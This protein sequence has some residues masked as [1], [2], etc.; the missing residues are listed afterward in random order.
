MGNSKY[1]P[2]NSGS[3]GSNYTLEIISI[4]NQIDPRTPQ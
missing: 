3:K 4:G 2:Y 1:H